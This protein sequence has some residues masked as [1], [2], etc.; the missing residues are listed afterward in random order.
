MEIR[1]YRPSDCEAL[2]E[3]FC[4]TVHTINA[5]D[6]TREQLNVWA[7]GNLDLEGWNQSL[8][9]HYSIVA[10][11]HGV[12]VG[13]GD[14]DR[15]GYLD[16]LFVHKDYQGRGI[17]TAICDRLE[18]AVQGKIVSHV[19][20]TAKPFFERRGYRVLE[21]Q[22]VERQGVF[23]TNYVMEKENGRQ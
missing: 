3:L 11:E 17:A 13:F 6:Y 10:V 5:R 18:G 23:L 7:S 15:T 2:A 14:M 19:S 8:L 12:I 20:I 1:T 22:R 4:R 21:E 9:A 16:R